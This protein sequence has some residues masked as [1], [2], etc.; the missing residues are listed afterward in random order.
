M[1]KFLIIQNA[2]LSIRFAIR[3]VVKDI[4]EKFAYEST[5]LGTKFLSK[6]FCPIVASMFLKFLLKYSGQQLTYS[7]LSTFIT[8][9]TALGF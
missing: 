8:R 1:F 2:H 4:K 3:C 5:E 7:T 9:A 6:I